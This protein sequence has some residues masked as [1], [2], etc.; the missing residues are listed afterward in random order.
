MKRFLTIT[1][2]STVLATGAIA[3]TEAEK[4][5]IT[6]YYPEANFET[7]TE[8]QVSE[9]FAIANG[10]MSDND[11]AERIETIANEDATDVETAATTGDV[12]L[13]AYVPAWRLAEMS[14]AEIAQLTAL[15]TEGG[16]MDDLRV[17]LVESM[18]DLQPQLTDA[19]VNAV[20]D[21]VPE[22]D[23]TVLTGEQVEQIR[24]A[25]YGYQDDAEQKSRIE[26]VLS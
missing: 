8:D 23:L 17:Q 19:E 4:N 18:S 24:A 5:A 9:M 20:Q 7:L 22:A 13:T 16:D 14:D 3:A 21:L 6:T 10:G 11:K 15:V 26:M 25:L 12:D 2:L 1:A